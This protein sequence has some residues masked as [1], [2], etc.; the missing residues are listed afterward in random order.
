MKET[1]TLH[2]SGMNNLY[3]LLV[4]TKFCVIERNRKAEPSPFSC[5]IEERL[6]RIC[7]IKREQYKHVI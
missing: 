5:S 1:Y 2:D 4:N 3:I 7:K 6:Q